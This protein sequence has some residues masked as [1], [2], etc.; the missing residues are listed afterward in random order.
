[1]LPLEINKKIAEI[2]NIK[3]DQFTEFDF[4]PDSNTI[5]CRKNWAENIADAFELFK[6]M[7]YEYKIFKADYSGFEEWIVE[8]NNERVVGVEKT[9]PLA[10]C[11]AWLKWK[12]IE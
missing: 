11:L 7:P 4:D 6:E 5:T 2:K 9:A 1:M 10:I 8:N 3:F 12:E